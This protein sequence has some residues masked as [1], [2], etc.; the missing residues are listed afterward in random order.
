MDKKLT[1]VLIIE[2]VAGS[3]ATIGLY[4]WEKSIPVCEEMGCLVGVPQIYHLFA[5]FI[6][7]VVLLITLIVSSMGN[8][9]RKNNRLMNIGVV[10][11]L[12]AVFIY[13]YFRLQID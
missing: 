4:F 5:I 13:M 3:L 12:L 10:L 6:T 1:L 11:V 2:G 8:V 9:T 7:I